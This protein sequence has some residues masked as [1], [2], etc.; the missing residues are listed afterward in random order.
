MLNKVLDNYTVAYNKLSF[1]QQQ[2]IINDLLALFYGGS[3]ELI[4]R[5]TQ[6]KE[7]SYSDQEI[8]EMIK[9]ETNLDFWL[10]ASEIL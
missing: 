10:K 4:S 2:E 6:L 3:E 5:L 1:E 8:F 9:I 7:Q